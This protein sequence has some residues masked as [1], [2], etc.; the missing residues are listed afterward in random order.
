MSSGIAAPIGGRSLRTRALGHEG[1]RELER[2]RLRRHLRVTTLHA[3]ENIA[4]SGADAGALVAEAGDAATELRGFVSTL[5]GAEG[6]TAVAELRRQ[7]AGLLHDSTL[8]A[9]EYLA[10]DGYG[11]DLDAATVRQVA[12]DAAVELRGN[13]LRLGAPEPCELVA[14][15]EQV[16]SAA[17]RRGTVEVEM[18]TDLEGSVYGADAAALVGAVREALNNVHKHANASHVL[19]R[20]ETSETGVRVVVSDDG[21]G[22]DLSHVEAGIGLR[23]SIVERMASRGGRAHVTSE[24][25]H[26]MLVT[27]VTAGPREVAA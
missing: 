19:V 13:L 5:A 16:V 24:P 10:S 15:L 6:R 20:C 17:Q 23:H 14:A 7:V 8:Q 18:V 22:V 25:G 11:A 9:M 12:A 21:V 1:A 27:L 4:G 3:L 2:K 26:G